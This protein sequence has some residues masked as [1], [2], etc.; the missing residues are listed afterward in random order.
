M[1][2]ETKQTVI[3]F[4]IAMLAHADSY[5]IKMSLIGYPIIWVIFM[6]KIFQKII[7]HARNFHTVQT[8]TKL[9]HSTL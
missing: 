1:C 8:C 6:H 4:K 5:Y 2:W 9:L 3:L 7:F